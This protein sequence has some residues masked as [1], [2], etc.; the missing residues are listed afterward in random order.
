MRELDI[1]GE[2]YR[3]S[4]RNSSNGGTTNW[5]NVVPANS[6]I[7]VYIRAYEDMSSVSS[8]RGSGRGSGREVG[9]VA[10]ACSVGDGKNDCRMSAYLGAYEDMLLKRQ[11]EMQCV[12][13]R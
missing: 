9:A 4:L 12:A 5:W 6:R 2:E 10:I 8:G 1:S 13:G 11:L 7:S 3:Q